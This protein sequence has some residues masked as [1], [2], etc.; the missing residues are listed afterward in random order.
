MFAVAHRWAEYAKLGL[1]SALFRHDLDLIRGPFPRR[2]A[3][4]LSWLDVDTVLDVGANIG[5]YASALRHSGYRGRIVSFEPLSDAYAHLRARASRDAHW[6]VENTAVGAASA[7]MSINVSAN[8][9][10]SSALLVTANHLN[11]APDSKVIRVEEVPVTT[12]IELCDRH[13]AKPARTLLKVDTQGYEAAVLDGAGGLLR[14]FAAI[15]LELSVVPLYTGQQ[16]SDE[17]TNRLEA[18]G[19]TL[20]GLEPGIADP[21]TGRLLQYDGFFVRADLAACSDRLGPN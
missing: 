7:S 9:Y 19:F 11:A 12:V 2:V 6:S 13:A 21:V 3:R 10:S 5:Q 18:A 15:Q 20:F 4:S 8:S 17:L 1:R 14:Q 16:L